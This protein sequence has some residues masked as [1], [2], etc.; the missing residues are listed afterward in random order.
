MGLRF[1]TTESMDDS[2]NCYSLSLNSSES[3][4]GT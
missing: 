1:A 3:M 2:A 4:C